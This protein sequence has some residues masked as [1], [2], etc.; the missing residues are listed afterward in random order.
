MHFWTKNTEPLEIQVLVPLF[1]KQTPFVY[2]NILIFIKIF[3]NKKTS[4]EPE[5]FFVIQ[6]IHCSGG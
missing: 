3:Q 6:K 1:K 4:G 2:W 5:V